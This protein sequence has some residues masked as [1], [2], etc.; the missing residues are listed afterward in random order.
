MHGLSDYKDSTKPAFFYGLYRKD[1]ELMEKHKSLLVLIWRGSDILQPGHIEAAKNT[2][3]NVKHVAISSFICKDL[4]N[5]GIKY[6]YLPIVGRPVSDIRPKPLGNEVYVYLPKTRH[7]FFNADIVSHIKKKCKYKVNIAT[8]INHYSRKE[9]LKVYKRCF[10]GIRL[11][12]HDGL[13]NQV[14]EMGLM[15]R[16]CIYNGNLP[17]S[18][19]WDKDNIDGI[20]DSINDEAKNIG[21][22]NKRLYKDIKKFINIGDDWLYL[23]YWK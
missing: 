9:L 17:G 8:H 14:V 7:N 15:G 5:A 16:K 12:N 2:K 20:I 11:S 19:K 3:T 21:N 13:P 18:I 1:V 4:D 23:D 22:I 6:I 10:C